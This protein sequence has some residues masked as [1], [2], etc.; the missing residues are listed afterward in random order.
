MTKE[1][2]QTALQ[3]AQKKPQNLDFATAA[4][5]LFQQLG[6]DTGRSLDLGDEPYEQF[7]TDFKDE[8]PNFFNEKLALVHEWQSIANLFQLTED[9]II[10]QHSL[11]AANS[12]DT[13]LKNWQSYLF[14][15]VELA[16]ENYTRTALSDITR[17]LNRLY[18]AP[19]TVLFRY[20]TG[21]NTRLTLAVTS[22]RPSKTDTSQVVTG[23]VTLIKDINCA[24]PHRAHLDI[25]SDLALT[26][27]KP[28]K[29]FMEFHAEWQRVLDL[30]EL[31]KKFYKELFNWYLWAR[32]TVQF[33][34]PAAE[35]TDNENIQ[36]V[37]TIRL[38]TRLIFIW[39][40]KEKGLVSD[41]VFDKQKVI[42]LLKNF[43]ADST[44]MGEYYN[45]ILQ[46]LFFATLNSPLDTD[47]TDPYEKRQFIEDAQKHA[48]N[49]KVYT[50][51]TKYRCAD[52][53]VDKSTAIAAFAAVPFLNGGLFEC[54]DKR[55]GSTETRYDGFSNTKT[56]RATVPNALF[57]G[58]STQDFSA[59]LDD[60]KQN[61]V[62]VRG[63]IDIL[64]SYKFT[65]QENTPLEEE[66]ALD[67]ELLGKVFENLLASY[68]PET[69]TTAR[70]QTGSFYTPREIV[71]YM[72]EQSLNAYLD[73]DIQNADARSQEDNLALI[74]KISDCKILDPACGS[75]AYP[76]GILHK[77]VDLLR[78][79]DPEN[80]YWRAVQEQKASDDTK[81]AYGEHDTA[82]R[83]KRLDYIEQVFTEN[84]NNP[85]YARKLFLIEN[86]IFGVDIQ[87][88][89]I[90]ISKLRFFIS[91]L[92]EQNTDDTKPNR[93][94][95]SMPNLETKFVTANTLIGL[96]SNKNTLTTEK[97]ERL[98][99]DLDALREQ[100]FFVKKYAAKNE[101]KTKEKETRAAL[102]DALIASGFGEKNAALK[103]EWNPFDVT[104]SAPFF[105]TA[106]MFGYDMKDGFDIVVGNPPY[107]EHKKLK[108]ISAD[109][110]RIYTKTYA[111]T[112][113]LYVYF[114]ENGLKLLNS[115]GHL[116][117]ITSN[118][119]IKTEY[120][121]NL[122][123][124]LAENTIEQIIDFT[125]V[126]V[127][128]ALVASCIVL[129]GREEQKDNKVIFVNTTD[130]FQ[131]LGVTDFVKNNTIHIDQNS[132]NPDLWLLEN[133][134]KSRLKSK[135]ETQCTLIANIKGVEVYRG[136]TTGYN[137]AF[138]IDTATKNELIAAEPQSADII[139]PL[140]Q[141]RNIRKWKYNFNNEYLL[142]IP[143]HFP[144]HEDETVNGNSLKAENALKSDYP[145]I[146]NH[147]SGHREGLSG[148]NKE[149]TGIRYEWY[150]LQRC[151]STYYSEFA[152]PKIIWG[153]TADKWAFAYD[154]LG[155][156][157]P[158]N[159]YI[160]T[161]K[162]LNIK[163]LL[164][165]LNS[166]VLKYYFSFIGIMTAGGAYTLKHSSILELP[167]KNI[168]LSA[169]APFIALV[170]YILYL[171]QQTF[172]AVHD[173]IMSPYFERVLDGMVYEL[174]FEDLL[175]QH[176]REIL[177]YLGELP[178]LT[179]TMSD[180]EKLSIVRT[181][182]NR[183]YDKTHQV[184]INLFFMDSIAEIG[185][186][187]KTTR[188]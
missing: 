1:N 40:L 28:V 85:D 38:L 141:G 2:I 81:K 118:K 32:R 188:M 136:V 105:D 22:R 88:I 18:P 9:E 157:L 106:T 15:G 182:F 42:T 60:K 68:N 48:R 58:A 35:P 101:L 84:T 72:V 52:L 75:G 7:K 158:S 164:A 177:Q 187:A 113:D 168:S 67:P 76:M 77:M 62:A 149:E 51:Q 109:L 45:G 70:K 120:G 133:E 126:H 108:A 16:G 65:I 170:E 121:K 43:A 59:D 66:I 162:T 17:Q 114:Y 152:E 125:A 174:Y 10:P 104:A 5:A 173:R 186:I 4:C 167:I 74:K 128:D 11:F 100:L 26:N 185:L 138:I 161:S 165:L 64:D 12:K 163:Y 127:F 13:D 95:L 24:N 178:A 82:E 98:E 166:N 46:N 179:A 44:E 115:N 160:L 36:S 39:F 69:K 31:N 53:F 102:R 47:T 25:L 147:L 135:I 131:H 79:L 112:A 142:F 50:D 119:F 156:Y 155:H 91:L 6:Y 107:V 148:R 63:I 129:V 89:A 171:K 116:C 169:Q 57:F 134:N 97:V 92:A 124:Y 30:K 20:G 99:K 176:G 55:E 159:G 73:V 180:E 29:D 132:L 130:D 27:L 122:R 111:G 153:L 96:E 140:L 93:G 61:K 23:K 86:C 145:E 139:K 137:P 54:L 184:C 175:K 123:R 87:A 8:I 34:K 144:L 21:K 151:A 71:D 56:K 19:V 49:S 150:A 80:Q 110:K 146:Y 181:V 117:F 183:L 172:E 83:R 103:T 3:N 33:P 94:I 78:Q 41:A 143:W 37:A 154:E 90:Q 14:F